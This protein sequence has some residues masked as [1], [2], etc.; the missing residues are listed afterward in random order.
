VAWALNCQPH[1]GP[2]PVAARWLKRRA[3][4]SPTA[5][6]ISRRWKCGNRPE[7][8]SGCHGCPMR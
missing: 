8:G 4:R 2:V 7:T 1:D 6:G 3:I 5:S